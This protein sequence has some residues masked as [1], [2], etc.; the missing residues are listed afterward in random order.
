M[1]NRNGECLATII[2]IQAIHVVQSCTNTSVL[3]DASHPSTTAGAVFSTNE[4]ILV[5]LW[6]TDT[7]A[8]TEDGGMAWKKS[9]IVSN[10]QSN[11]PSIT[12]LRNS[13][14]LLCNNQSDI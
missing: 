10:G 13:C 3:T 6:T 8:Q 1:N 4:Q 9:T 5:H 12:A 2:I 14:F 7:A 11:S